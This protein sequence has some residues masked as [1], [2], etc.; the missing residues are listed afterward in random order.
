MDYVIYFV[1]ILAV[2]T[3]ALYVLNGASYYL[4]LNEYKP[5]SNVT[6]L[7]K[8]LSTESIVIYCAPCVVCTILNLCLLGSS[9]MSVLLLVQAVAYFALA[10]VLFSS[11][12]SRK[13]KLKLT[14]RFVRLYLLSLLLIAGFV[15]YWCYQLVFVAPHLLMLIYLTP[16]LVV[17]VLF[18]AQVVLYPVEKLIYYYYLHSAVTML[19]QHGG[20]VNIAITGSYGKTSTK[21]MLKSI[22]SEKY[23]VCATPNSYNTPIG[24]TKTIREMLSP[25]HD[26][27]IMEFG[28]KKKGEIKYLCRKFRPN[29]GVLTSIG[30]AHLS[31]FKTQENIVSTKN[32]LTHNLYGDHKYMVFNADDSKVKACA[33]TCK[34][35]YICCGEG[36]TISARNIVCTSSGCTFEVYFDDKYYL[37]ARTKL[38]GKHNVSNILLCVAVA[39]KLRLSKQQIINGIASITPVAGRLEVVPHSSGAVIINDGYNSNPNSA[40]VAVDTLALYGNRRKIIVTPGMV[41]LGNSQYQENYEWAKYIA[42]KVDK[43]VIVNQVN[44]QALFDGLV[45]G[46]MPAQNIALDS[47]LKDVIKGL[48]NNDVLLIENDLPDNYN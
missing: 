25:T 48:Q 45:A 5:L 10:F 23:N 39:I 18:A 27:F 29:I 7:L 24:I 13:V 26:I 36:M 35:D 2:M 9:I 14:K 47:T 6:T 42:R 21:F 38:I 19:K 41:E 4:Q 8:L 44:K 32:E 43:V 28:A 3:F 17:L 30:K 15:G 31:T 20:I 11:K 1:T 33:D 46:G 34:C 40:R 16:L 37:T 22:L 12:G